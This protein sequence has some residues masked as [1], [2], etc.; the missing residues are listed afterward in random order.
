MNRLKILRETKGL[1]QERLA[2]ELNVSQTMISKYELGQ[3]EP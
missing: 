3:A 2:I 1:S